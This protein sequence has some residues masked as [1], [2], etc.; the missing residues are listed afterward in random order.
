M[1]RLNKSRGFFIPTVAS[2]LIGAI[3][4]ATAT[5][6]VGDDAASKS[7]PLTVTIET[8]SGSIAQLT[9]RVGAG[10]TLE[11]RARAA[12]PGFTRVSSSQPQPEAVEVDRPM[13]VFIDGPTGYTYVWRL[14][15]GWKFVG[16]VSER[17]Y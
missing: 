5:A 10:W 2:V 17:K 3:G 16:S 13:T 15:D 4:L 14:G 11:E 7:S 1:E 6:S 8:P 9:Y 12:T